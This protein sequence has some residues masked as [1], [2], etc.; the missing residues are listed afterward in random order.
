MWNAIQ[1]VDLQDGKTIAIVGI[2]G[3]GLLGVQMAKALGYRVAAIDN[4]DFGLELAN[5]LPESLR[6]DIAV[7][8]D[9]AEATEKL[10]SFT[11]GIGLDAAIVCTDSV[12]ANDWTLHRLRIRGTCV[13]LGLPVEGFHFDAFNIVFRELVIRGSLHSGIKEVEKMLEI[14]AKHKILSH[15]TVIQLE[16]AETVPEKVAA[17]AFEGRLVIKM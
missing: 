1:Q 16:E 6:P 3:L 5:K 17:R 8:I 7:G 11:D 4:S 2:G 14:V 12:S 10:S 9:S 13:V 15:V